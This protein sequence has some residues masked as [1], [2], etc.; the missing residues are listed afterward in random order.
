MMSHSDLN[1]IRVIS[2]NVNSLNLSTRLQLVDNL[3]RFD[4]KIESILSKNADIILLQDTRLGPDGHNILKK[5]LEFSKYGSFSLF[6]NSTKTCRGVA[7]IIKE[8]LPYKLVQSVSC[9][10]E[11]YLLLK[12]SVRDSIFIIGSVYSP[13]LSQDTFFMANLEQD[14]LNFGIDK[15]LIGGDLNMVSDARK[16]CSINNFNLDIKNMAQIPNV[17]NSITLAS[18]CE[19]GFVTN[20]FR[21]FYQDRRI[22]SHVPFNKNDHSRSRIDHFL[23][24]TDFINSFSNLTYLAIDSKLFDHKCVLLETIKK[25]KQKPLLH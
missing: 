23:C 11:N 20:I 13:M 9:P 19:K 21:H 22:F 1:G 10:L 25:I 18:W 3:N 7:V 4:Q 12:I 15:F 17:S 24:S 5:R 6:S 2:Q 14:I 16:I 8:T